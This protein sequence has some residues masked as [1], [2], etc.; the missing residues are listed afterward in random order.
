MKILV[1]SHEFPPLI[2]GGG[3]SAYL[4]SSELSKESQVDVLTPYYNK[5]KRVEKIGNMNIFRVKV[6]GRVN[7]EFQSKGFILLSF[8]SFIFF[9]TIKG[10][11]LAV[12][13]RYDIIHS[14]F[15]I[16]SGLIGTVISFLTKIPHITTI[17]EADVFDP[18][19]QCLTPYKSIFIKYTI[20]FV[21]KFS[22][23]TISISSYIADA[24]KKFYLYPYG[25]RNKQILVINL[26]IDLIKYDKQKEKTDFGFKQEDFVLISIGRLV[27]RKNFEGLI[28]IM[29]EIEDEKVKLVI[30]GNGPEYSMLKEKVERYGLQR[31]VFFLRNLADK[32]KYEYLSI[33]DVFVSTTLHE[34]FGIVY[35]EAM[36]FG[37]PIVT[38][39]EG[40][41]T[42]LITDG[43]NGF[44]VSVGDIKSFVEKIKLLRSNKYLYERIKFNNLEKIKS[45]SIKSV[46]EKYMKL[47]KEVINERYNLSIL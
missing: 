42:D 37:L 36:C 35:L 6:F 38:T 17:Y 8:A 33:S 4:I 5:L 47:F 31:K 32:E 7:V 46:A 1:I 25:E 3:K 10:L 41:Q 24:T 27:K 23:R 26:G 21:I 22:K 2:G 45:F 20:Y 40:G 13:N 30:V 44:L 9:G 16:P 43:E 15:V 34:G 39:N 28:E 14:H 19:Y 29:R 11:L 18:R 12:K